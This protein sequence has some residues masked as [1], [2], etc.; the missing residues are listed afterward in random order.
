MPRILRSQLPDGFFH[1][2][3]R[4]VDGCTIFR[5]DDDRRLFL[6]LLAICVTRYRWS[7]YAFCLMTNHYHLVVEATQPRL[8][9][10]MQYLSGRYAQRFNVRHGRTGHLFGGR[11]TSQVFPGDTLTATATVESVG[12]GVVELKVSTVNQDGVE[13]FSGR[14]TAAIAG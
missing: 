12:G 3:I 4:G 10:G 14:A 13:V 9:S 7:V 2:T 1:V 5:D 6:K 11:F 8:S